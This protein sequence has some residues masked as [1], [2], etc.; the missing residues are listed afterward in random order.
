MIVAAVLASGLS[1][2][3]GADKLALPFAGKTVLWHAVAPLLSARVDRIMVVT[4]PGKEYVLPDDARIESLS[5]PDHGEGMA[6]S[7]RLAC[8]RTGPEAESLMV[9]LGDKPLLRSE[10]VVEAIRRFE[11]ESCDV[12]VS[13]FEGQAGHPVLFASRLMPAL[14]RLKGDEG[15]RRIVASHHGVHR[16]PCDDEG[17][18]FDIDTDEDYTNLLSRSRA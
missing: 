15:A 9:C 13:C 7:L 3:M 16:F 11:A 10:T 5:N 18:V 17:V 6:S 8:S 12:L 1:Q 2:R 14:M 4:A